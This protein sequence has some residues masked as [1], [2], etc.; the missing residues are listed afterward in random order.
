MAGFSGGTGSYQLGSRDFGFTVPEGFGG[1]ENP[2][3]K[4][5][6]YGAS[7]A[8]SPD[9]YQVDVRSKN[10]RALEEASLPLLFQTLL[11]PQ[12]ISQG[13]AGMAPPVPGAQVSGLSSFLFG[14]APSPQGQAMPGQGGS[15]GGGGGYVPP[16]YGPGTIQPP[17]DP[18]TGQPQVPGGAPVAVGESGNPTTRQ[19]G[20]GQPDPFN[21]TNSLQQ[22]ILN[23]AERLSPTGAAVPWQDQLMGTNAG[24]DSYLQSL[25][26][27]YAGNNAYVNGQP[28]VGSGVT[29]LGQL[30]RGTQQGMGSTAGLPVGAATPMDLATQLWSLLP[31]GGQAQVLRGGAS[32]AGYGDA[33]TLMDFLSRIGF[34]QGSP[35]NMVGAPGV[36]GGFN[37][38]IQARAF[39]GPLDPNALTL[40]G[41]RG[42]ELITP[43]S[44]GAQQVVPLG[45]Q[46]NI[47]APPN[48]GGSPTG[49]PS[50]PTPGGS[51]MASSTGPGMIESLLSQNPEQQTFDFS[52]NF[53]QQPG[54]ILGQGGNAGAG[55]MAALQ[56]LF[57]QNLRFGIN[58]LT[59]S[60]PSVHNSGAAITGADVTSRAM[61]DYNVLAAQAMQQGQQTSLSGLGMLGQLAGQAGNGAFNRALGAGQ[62]TT[63]RDLGMSQLNQQ[64]QQQQ[65][66]QTVNPTLQLL[67][68]ALGMATPT[69]YQTVVNQG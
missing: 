10:M 29:A 44:G 41:E 11:N 63:Q 3:T 56:P 45:G 39:G 2:A 42:P 21:Q 6:Y 37:G 46:M 26:P 24:L 13:I 65:W 1:P 12:S 68:A 8:V 20:D 48:G 32:Q 31:S 36:Q 54:G 57:Q 40:V 30:L 25:M 14:G 60:V 27:M 4:E 51:G 64:Q 18:R 23:F 66:N 19:P 16:N 55:I 58:E 62:L 53:L 33:A 7:R 35:Q 15:G 22:Q 49:M 38:G 17:V 69:A 67:L 47:M 9:A 61:N 34:Q 59:N 50:L 52:K 28:S 5:N 43:G